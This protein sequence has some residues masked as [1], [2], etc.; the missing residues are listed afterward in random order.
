MYTRTR[1]F[2]VG[3]LS[4]L[5]PAPAWAAGDLTY[6][7]PLPP[8]CEL[9]PQLRYTFAQETLTV[10]V[11]GQQSPALVLGLDRAF[12]Q[13]AQAEAHVSERMAS[14]KLE[15]QVQR[16]CTEQTLQQI[17]CLD[18]KL[19]LIGQLSG[20]SC[21]SDYRLEL[22]ASGTHG[23]S[24]KVTLQNAEL[25]RLELRTVIEP[26][27]RFY[28]F[29]EQFTHLEQRGQVVPIWS[30]E[31]GIGRGAQPVTL[32]ANL[33]AGS[34]GHAH[35]TYAPIPFALSSE[36]RALFV[37]NSEFMSFD[38]TRKDELKVRVWSHQLE[39]TAW[40]AESPLAL[41][42][43]FTAM[44]GRMPPLPAW[45]RGSWLGLQG[46]REKVLKVLAAAREAGNPV[47][48]LWLQDWVGQR[49]TSFGSQLWWRWQVDPQRYPEFKA[50]CAQ[51]QAEGVRVLGYINPF[52]ADEGPLFEEARSKGYL[53]KNAQGEDYRIQTAGF[54]AYLV[55][56]THP[57]A[58]RWL[59]QLIRTELIGV[60]LS[61]WMADFGEWLPFD[62]SLHSGISAASYHNQ[63]PVDWAR[64]NREAIQE[65]GREGD[66]VFFS[67]AGFSGSAQYSPLFWA[68]DQLVDWDE[69][70]GL[71]SA[72]TG[73]LTG[74][75]SGLTLNHSDIGGYT[76]LDFPG[77]NYHRS[78]ELLQR[79]SELS[80]F[81]PVF[82]THEGNRPSRNVQF[83]QNEVTQARF[84]RMARMHAALDSYLAVL[85]EEASTKGWP[86]MRA[87][88]LHHPQDKN[89]WQLRHQ[90]LLGQDVLVL[91]VVKPGSRH[92]RGYFP[93]GSWVHLLTGETVQ[94]GQFLKVSAPLGQ[95]AAYV[96]ADSPWKD[97]LLTA[98]RAALS[99]TTP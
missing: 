76:T 19:S 82:R 91:P 88:Y 53:V 28:G 72:I 78:E 13:A 89:T 36:Q 43:H 54:P 15:E 81:T 20:P 73:M 51:L 26:S 42:T 61:G 79:W 85:E 45:S 41:L 50:L 34:G 92:V 75:M 5:A 98:I 97:P 3:L 7:A 23:L 93:S 60:G 84:A 21:R 18:G 95:P 68:G 30:E 63:Y 74:G 94:G 10:E 80:V 86:V 83:Y 46:G 17:T 12:L 62:A 29:G 49:T 32:G 38:L 47:S 67:R 11:V 4:L 9:A 69:H 14:Y 77:R 65:A 66:I 70:D 99:G 56:L 71:A 59:K 57:E 96:R 90:F 2:L 22:K 1:N 39:A 35:S 6:T 48:A 24:L 87:L 25:N 55:D 16:R 31:Q 37:Q 33:V 40:A 27:E 52:L 8:V 44:T 58:V 64:L